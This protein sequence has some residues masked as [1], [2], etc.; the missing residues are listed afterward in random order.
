MPALILPPLERSALLLDLD[1]TLIDIAPTPDTVVVPPGLVPALRTL[2]DRLGGALAVVSGRRV[3]EVDRLLEDAPRAV[4]GE[5]GVGIRHAPDAPIE[6]ANLPPPPDD[7]LRDAEALIAAWPGALMERKARGFTMH[8]RMN[9][10]AGPVFH[11]LLVRV[12]A[13]QSAFQ[14]LEGNMVWEVRPVGADKGHAVAA[15]M[16]RAPFAGRVPI[17]I[18][19]DVTDEDGMRVARAMGGVGLRVDA[20]FGSAAGVRTWIAKAAETGVWPEE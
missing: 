17:F 13:D 1:G 6:R 2:R 20:A 19:D 8:F 16:A 18:G 4:A 14:L 3:A 7:W 5:H 9:P 11:A 12:L 10:P 15:L